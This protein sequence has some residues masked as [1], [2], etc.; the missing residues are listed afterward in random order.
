M[1]VRGRAIQFSDL[2]GWKET[3]NTSPPPALS[4]LTIE[5]RGSNRCPVMVYLYYKRQNTEN[6]ITVEPRNLELDAADDD[7]D[8]LLIYMFWLIAIYNHHKNKIKLQIEI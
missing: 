5:N 2:L 1:G 6:G 8:D 4:S 7:D 3:R